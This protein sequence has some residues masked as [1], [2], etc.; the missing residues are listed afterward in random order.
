MIHVTHLPIFP[1][2]NWIIPKPR[3]CFIGLSLS[4]RLVLPCAVILGNH[5]QPYFPVRHIVVSHKTQY[6]AV[7]TALYS[8]S[9]ASYGYCFTIGYFRNASRRVKP[10]S[11]DTRK[12][13][14]I[15]SISWVM[16]CYSCIIFVIHQYSVH[17]IYSSWFIFWGCI[18]RHVWTPLS[19]PLNMTTHSPRASGAHNISRAGKSF[20]PNLL[21]Y[22][23]T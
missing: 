19:K 1:A 16:I 20:P 13:T 11:N 7:W 23:V 9:Y 5:H 2:L 21:L 15:V 18:K 6:I 22:A 4:A 10:H 17:Y 3:A 12:W 14:K 8:S